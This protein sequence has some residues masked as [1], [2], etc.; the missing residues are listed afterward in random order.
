[1]TTRAKNPSS[2]R[3][4]RQAKKSRF[5]RLVRA[6][7]LR[8]SYGGTHQKFPRRCSCTLPTRAPPA[9]HSSAH[10]ASLR[11]ADGRRHDARP[12]GFRWRS[13]GELLRQPA[14]A[15]GLHLQRV[16]QEL[17]LGGQVLPRAGPPRGAEDNDT[18]RARARYT[19]TCYRRLP[20]HFVPLK[21]RG[22]TELDIRHRTSRCSQ[23]T[24][25]QCAE[26][27]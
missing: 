21:P 18:P 4:C 3:G 17:S 26:R 2:A 7:D 15:N 10:S 22:A 1:M 6:P 25:W 16:E 23:I 13:S 8:L 27:L 19:N 9:V 20:F 5:V 14:A 24:G 11:D 12:R